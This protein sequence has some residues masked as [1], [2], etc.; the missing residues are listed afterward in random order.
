MVGLSGWTY[1]PPSGVQEAR[2]QGRTVILS[3]GGA[4]SRI[5]FDNR[6]ISTAFVDSIDTINN[7]WGGTRERPAFDGLDLNTHEATPLHEHGEY[8]WIGQ[9]LKR[10]FGAGFLIT[11]PPAPWDG[12]DRELVRAMFAAGVLD[13]AAPQYYGGPGL[14]DP[15][16]IVSSVRLWVNDV[17]G[18][19]ASKIVVGFGIHPGAADY[20]TTTGVKQAW[21]QIE[22][23]FPTDQRR[24]PVVHRRRPEQRVGF[25]HPGSAG[26]P[27]LASARGSNR[28]S[29]VRGRSLTNSASAGRTA[30]SR[31]P[32][33]PAPGMSPRARD[34]L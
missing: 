5:A 27:R 26:R 24:V 34:K 31:C 22:A 19:D 12:G 25:R 14:A 2:A 7:G 15:G 4:G 13:Y 18:G 8:V 11:T 1:P 3:T 30:G 32:P 28:A 17:A 6:A 21:D 16:Y 20:T 23:E 10:R 29:Q 9:E 33:D